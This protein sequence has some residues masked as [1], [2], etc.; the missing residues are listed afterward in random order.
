MV[1][2]TILIFFPKLKRFI[3]IPLEQS[4]T[5]AKANYNMGED[6]SCKE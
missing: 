3:F 2:K 5:K 6:G 1:Q 4:Y